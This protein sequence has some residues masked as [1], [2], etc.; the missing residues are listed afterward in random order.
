MMRDEYDA[1]LWVEYHEALTSG[2]DRG[3][4]ALRS[5]AGRFAAWDGSSHQLLALL[6][7]FAITGLS[8]NTTA[9]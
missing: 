9:A 8:F 3:L 1:R 4:V 7:A 6:L 2:I 5:A